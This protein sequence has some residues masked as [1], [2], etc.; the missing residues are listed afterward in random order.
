MAALYLGNVHSSG[1]VRG[2]IDTTFPAESRRVILG[3]AGAILSLDW[4]FWE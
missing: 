1:I 2:I 3:H 4:Y